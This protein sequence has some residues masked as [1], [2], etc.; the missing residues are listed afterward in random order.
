MKANDAHV[1][2]LPSHTSHWF[3]PL[4]AGVFSSFKKAWRDEMRIFTRDTAGRKLDKKDF[5]VYLIHR[6]IKP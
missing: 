4:D 1:F 2:V 5:S 3:Q 6:G